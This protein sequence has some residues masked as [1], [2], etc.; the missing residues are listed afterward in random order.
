MWLGASPARAHSIGERKEFVNRESDQRADNSESGQSE[1]VLPFS[2]LKVEHRRGEE[3]VCRCDR[4][5]HREQ[6][7]AE[8]EQDR[9]DEDRRKERKVVGDP[10][11]EIES[12]ARRDGEPDQNRASANAIS[13]S[14]GRAE[15][16]HR[17]KPSQGRLAPR[18]RRLKTGQPKTSGLRIQAAKQSRF[19]RPPPTRAPTSANSRKMVQTP[20]ILNFRR[21][22][23]QTLN[24]KEKSIL[25]S[26]V[27]VKA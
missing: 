5:N 1:H 27:S 25:Q 4:G 13:C 20:G 21:E 18:R 16:A 24:F 17:W 23:A 11:V 26:Q 2:D 14:W 7:R 9:A 6:T 8:T 19:Q 10:R 22:L 3:E 15:F 12:E